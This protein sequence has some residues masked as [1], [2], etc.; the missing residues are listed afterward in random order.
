MYAGEALPNGMYNIALCADTTEFV[1]TVG[2]SM[3]EGALLEIL[4]KFQ[5][6]GR[7]V[8]KWVI[9]PWADSTHVFSFRM[10]YN[11]N[12]FHLVGNQTQEGT[13]M[14]ISDVDI[15]NPIYSQWRVE[16][17][18][19]GYF[20]IKSQADKNK[21]LHTVGHSHAQSTRL[22]ILSL[23]SGYAPL[24]KWKFNLIKT[25]YEMKHG[26][27]KNDEL[28]ETVLSDN[29][30]LGMMNVGPIT[31]RAAPMFAERGP[32]PS[33]LNYWKFAAD[34]DDSY[35]LSNGS[36][37]NLYV[38]PENG[39]L[40][41]NTVMETFPYSSGQN[42]YMFVPE[43]P[44]KY[45]RRALLKLAVNQDLCIAATKPISQTRLTLE[46]RKS[47][48][49][50]SNTWAFYQKNAT[51]PN[52]NKQIYD[53]KPGIYRIVSA[54][55]DT[56]SITTQDY[57]WTTGSKL[58]LKSTTADNR[59]TSHYWVVDYEKD[60]NGNP[61][62]DGTYTIQLFATDRFYF[63]TNGSS[64]AT[65]TAVEIYSLDRNHLFSVKWFIKPTRDGSGTYFVNIA[66]DPAQYLHLTSHSTAENTALEI[67]DAFDQAH[68]DTYKWFFQPVSITAPFD[69]GIHKVVT[70]K[71]KSKF[72]H[73][74]GHST[75]NE[76]KLEILTYNQTYD[77][78]YSWKFTKLEDNTYM[79]QN[80]G[81][82]RFVHPI[83]HSTVDGT[84]LQ[85]LDY[86]TGYA[87]YYKWIIAPGTEANTYR[88]YSVANP[89]MLIH[90]SGHTAEESNE[91]EILLYNATYPWTYDWIMQ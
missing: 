20:Y 15:H 48:N 42:Y 68:A 44:N 13:R 83:G 86:T 21:Y 61:V 22:E 49:S 62:L 84:R 28:Y 63:H 7:N 73:V 46:S 40:T 38:R 72:L 91:V 33:L 36:Y 8:Y 45:G 74:W 19:D 29:T 81:S 77:K 64:L 25:E 65:S 14:E 35:V 39:N 58:V 79:I 69:T 57:Q 67:Y 47:N 60:N 17:A 54:A 76:A 70:Q 88:I 41:E 9:K 80:V 27:Y 18:G 85:Q 4:P 16:P 3:E 31:E 56:K 78:I 90:L 10:A 23:N 71:D 11:R 82:S 1:H 53:L 2:H 55:D 89:N 32:Y 24:Y 75:E 87:P 6:E 52:A 59:Y 30:F 43:K 37:Y 12:E 26:A 50:N 5:G 34:W 51:S 66:G